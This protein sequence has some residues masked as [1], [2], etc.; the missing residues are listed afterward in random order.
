MFCW[1]GMRAEG[2]AEARCVARLEFQQLGYGG[3]GGGAVWGHQ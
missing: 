1:G 2:A 3:G